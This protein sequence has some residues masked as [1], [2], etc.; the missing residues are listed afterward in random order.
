MTQ[1]DKEEDVVLWARL[2]V[3]HT[4][5]TCVAALLVPIACTALVYF[6]KI[7]ELSQQTEDDYSVRLVSVRMRTF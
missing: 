4:K 7:F 1:K 2:S 3:K 6:S 5:K